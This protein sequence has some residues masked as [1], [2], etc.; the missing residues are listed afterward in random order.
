MLLNYSLIIRYKFGIKLWS[1]FGIELITDLTVHTRLLGW[2]KLFDMLPNVYWYTDYLPGLFTILPRKLCADNNFQSPRLSDEYAD[3]TVGFKAVK[4]P[5]AFIIS[6]CD[7][8][9]KCL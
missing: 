5:I 3:L 9:P 7:V 1:D 4:S 6:G 8:S 2:Y